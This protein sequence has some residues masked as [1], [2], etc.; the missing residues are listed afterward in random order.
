MPHY[1][2]SKQALTVLSVVVCLN[3]TTAFERI[4]NLFLT[5][6]MKTFGVTQTQIT[7]VPALLCLALSLGAITWPTLVEPLLGGFGPGTTVGLRIAILLYTGSL[8]AASFIPWFWL[9][10]VNI[11]ITGLG[12]S[13]MMPA[14]GVALNRWFIKYRM[15]TNQTMEMGRAV[16]VCTMP[17]VMQWIMATLGW[18][19]ALRVLA[20]LPL[21]VFIP[22]HLMGTAPDA[23]Q[24][25]Q[26]ISPPGSDLGEDD[27][28]L[29]ASP[30]GSR[31]NTRA[32][33]EPA[34]EPMAAEVK[35][36]MAGPPVYKPRANE[37]LLLKLVALGVLFSFLGMATGR[38]LAVAYA[39]GKMKA[40]GIQMTTFQRASL[41]TFFNWS[42]VGIRIVFIILREPLLKVARAGDMWFWGTL[43]CTATFG[44]TPLLC[45]KLAVVGLMIAACL[46]GLTL[47]IYQ[48]QP[49]TVLAGIVGTERMGKWMGIYTLLCGL[50]NFIGPVVI[51]KLCAVIGN[52]DWIYYFCVIFYT[53]A[54]LMTIPITRN[55]L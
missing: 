16:F 18:Q 36:V 34:I 30:A 12:M 46:Q 55:K 9:F 10:L 48:G 43:L 32:S 28:M 15:I 8:L 35:P 54:A 13:W 40:F 26:S 17:Y 14:S 25:P 27:K 1:P 24:R 47:G 41:V 37:P 11:V 39:D 38:T 49:I 7:L 29:P 6:W 21:L 33:D 45:N 44:I 42:S 19:W 3:F 31:K 2:D 50:G 51:S 23:M 5:P 20:V 53:L 52:S 4:S 22:I